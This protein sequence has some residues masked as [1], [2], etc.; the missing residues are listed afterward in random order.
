MRV[1][2]INDKFAG[3]GHLVEEMTI[4]DCFFRIKHENA[5]LKIV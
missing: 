3:A 4:V 2:I 1:D 5:G